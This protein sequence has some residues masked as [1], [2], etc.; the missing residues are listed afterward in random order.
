MNSWNRLIMYVFIHKLH[1]GKSWHPYNHTSACLWCQNKATILLLMEL[2][3]DEAANVLTLICR[4]YFQSYPFSHDHTARRLS[5]Y[6]C[7]FFSECQG[8]VHFH[9]NL[10]VLLK[11]KVMINF[12]IIQNHLENIQSLSSKTHDMAE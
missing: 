9:K 1:F 5:W 10:D 11:M 2:V 12:I 3:V 7:R 8:A 6:G 4:H